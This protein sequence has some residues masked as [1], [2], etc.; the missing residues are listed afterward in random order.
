MNSGI[1]DIHSAHVV[2]GLHPNAGGPSRTVVQLVDALSR[3]NLKV[4]LLS[5]CYGNQLITKPVERSVN[6]HIGKSDSRLALRLGLPLRRILYKSNVLELPT[7]IHSHGLWSAANYW[8]STASRRFNLPLIVHPRGMLEPWAL[9]HKK[10]KKILGL[11]IYQQKA[12][13]GASVLVAT[14]GSEY[15]NLR[16]LGLNNPIAIIPNGVVM[17]SFV[18][19]GMTNDIPRSEVRTVL[20]LSRV[21]EKKGLINLVHAWAQL[22][23]VGWRLQIAGPDENGH[24][25]KVMALVQHLGI[26]SI[27]EYVGVVDGVEKAALYRSADVFVLPTYSENFGVAVAEALASGLPVITTKGAP[28]SDLEKYNCGWW[29]DIGVQPLVTAL[30]EAIAL[31]DDERRAMGS[32]GRNYVQRYDWNDI[33]SQMTEVYRWVIG[34]GP[35]PDCIRV[36]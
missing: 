18:P 31:S 17:E 29:I 3:L 25:R 8:A 22:K 32:R 24:L 12:L 6:L 27:I 13:S 33:A 26:D 2:A 19:H 4:S 15:E 14:A 35:K 23:P 16:A 20:F 30:R 7:I 1:I 11:K 36:D 21:Q 9:S 28:W 34:Q 10:L 5:Q